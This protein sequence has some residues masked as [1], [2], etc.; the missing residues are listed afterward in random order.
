M[1]DQA[2]AAL[3]DS[4]TL[5]INP[6]QIVTPPHG[7]VQRELVIAFTMGTHARLGAA[8][9]VLLIHTGTGELL[10]L[11]LASA[12]LWL[13]L[14]PWVVTRTTWPADSASFYIANGVSSDDRFN[15][16][17]V[18]DMGALSD[19]LIARYLNE[20]YMDIGEITGTAHLT[21]TEPETL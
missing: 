3:Y 14:D 12:R 21:W 6:G 13:E 16:L 4:V 2:P 18:P 7:I 19:T 1:D 8:S 15:S 10:R 20:F 11:V 5:H 17:I 9:P